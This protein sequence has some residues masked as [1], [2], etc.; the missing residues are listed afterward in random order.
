MGSLNKKAAGAQCF[1]MGLGLF[2]DIETGLP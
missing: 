2:W 1:I